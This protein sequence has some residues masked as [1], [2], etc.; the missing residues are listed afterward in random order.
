V[1][2]GAGPLRRIVMFLYFSPPPDASHHQGGAGGVNS[3]GRRLERT[4][5][6]TPTPPGADTARPADLSGQLSIALI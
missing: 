6:F 4:E 3:K 1:R 2:S 5:L